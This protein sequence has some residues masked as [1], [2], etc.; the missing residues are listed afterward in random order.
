MSQEKKLSDVL[1]ERLD[2]LET[3]NK[4]LKTTLTLF[5]GKINEF[6]QRNR[7]PD[8]GVSA[9][10]QSSAPAVKTWDNNA[11]SADTHLN[12]LLECK[13]CNKELSQAY[14]DLVKC[15][16]CESIVRKTDPKC[17][18]CGSTEAKR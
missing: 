5:E 10:V 15:V 2:N 7:G 4:A 18:F 12:H 1:K 11:A 17:P 6:E 9:V 3:E 8:S 16:G 13:N 14:P